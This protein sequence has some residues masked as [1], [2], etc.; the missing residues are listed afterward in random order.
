MTSAGNCGPAEPPGEP[1]QVKPLFE[2][3]EVGLHRVG[4]D[5]RIVWANAAEMAMLGYQPEEYIGHHIGEFHADARVGADVLAYLERGQTF[6]DLEAR[7]RCKNGAIKTVLIDSSVLWVAGRSVHTQCFTRDI[8]DHKRAV[9]ALRQNEQTQRQL[10]S[11]LP[12][13][14]YTCDPEG[15]ITFCNR[16][17]IEIWGRDPLLN[18]DREKFNGAHKLFHMDGA[19]MPHAE[20]L[21]ASAVLRGIPARNAEMVVERADGIR[22]IVRSNIDPIRDANG[23]LKGAINVFENVTDR[24]RNEILTDGQNRALQLIVSGARLDAVLEELVRIAEAASCGSA[25]AAVMLL[26]ETG[27]RL[28]PAAA[29]RLPGDLVRALDRIPLG[30]DVAAAAAAA[31][32][33]RI[34]ITPS[35]AS[36][37]TWTRLREPPLDAG[38]RAAW[39]MPIVSSKGRVL[40]TFDCYFREV[41]R[42]VPE[43]IATVEVLCKT[44]AIAID[45]LRAE[46]ELRESRE[47]LQMAMA[48]GRM[49]SWNWDLTTGQFAWSPEYYALMGYEPSERL[50]SQEDWRRRMHPDDVDRVD[51][52]I[53]ETALRGQGYEE[54][55]RVIWPDGS[56]HWL[57]CRGKCVLGE[58]GR[59][60]RMTGVIFEI[61]ALK[62]AEAE[63]LRRERLY[64]GIG[65]SIDFGIWIC[66]PDGKIVYVSE[67]YLKLLGLTQEEYANFGWLNSLRPAD[68][69]ATLSAWKECLQSGDLWERELQVRGV[70]GE[71]RQVLARGVP[72]RDEDGKV[73]SWAGLHL[74]ITGLKRTERALRA[75]QAKLLQHAEELERKVLD[76]TASLR[77]AVTQVEE[78]SYTVSHDLRA[79]L[80]AMNGF[81]ELLRDECADRL[82]D[83]KYYLERIIYNG[84]RMEKLVSDLLTVSRLSRADITLERVSLARVVD[85]ILQ[86]NPAMQPPNATFRIEALPDVSAHEPSLRQILAN[87]FHNAIKFMTPGVRP[88]I[89]VGATAAQEGVWIWVQD[90]GI[91]VRREHQEKIF[92]LFERIH[93][94]SHYEGT[95]IGLAIVRRAAERMGGQVGIESDGEHGSRFWIYLPNSKE[96]P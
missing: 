62:A 87:L 65:E 49:G 88:E 19:P 56:V 80:R 14:V 51:R 79:P 73:T 27:D 15:R 9:E 53:R 63:L 57:Q 71:W 4:A 33:N 44:A 89:V 41:R 13:A 31:S 68:A 58:T 45:R 95:G 82:G 81:S 84:R 32:Q 74:D 94:E 42:P 59:T 72:V 24:K 61:T 52:A 60:V 18:D 7:L 25:V 85:E 26:N 35:I 43:D 30:P 46:A 96:H 20:G 37:P 16:R 86:E 10:M 78:F 36:D 6:H 67:S 64:R 29:P 91:G 23:V 21:M 11:L 66:D 55:Y 39:S 12:A 17:A 2:T 5:G 50:P 90:N 47:Q 93:P 69:E 40:G 92:E 1:G 8:S 34:V 48:A 22:L 77:Q 76:R 3:S 83:G 38:L 70:D 54:E 28:R 75:A